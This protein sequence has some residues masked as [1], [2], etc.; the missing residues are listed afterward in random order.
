MKNQKVDPQN[1]SFSCHL[2]LC[3]LEVIGSQKAMIHQI[4]SQHENRQCKI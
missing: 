1:K 3:N 4:E 2:D